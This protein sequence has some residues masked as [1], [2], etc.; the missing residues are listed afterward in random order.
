ME[1]TVRTYVQALSGAATRLTWGCALISVL[2]ASITASA[3]EADLQHG[4][5][6]FKRYCAGCHGPDGRGGAQTFMPHIDT[7]TKAGYIDLLPDEHLIGII[8]EGGPSVG[9]SSY[10]PAWGG[11]L[12]DKDINDIV[13]HIRTLPNY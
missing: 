6:L 4:E 2:F 8:K 10:M 12:S 11:T 1:G 13:A 5:R 9:K 7:L 3:Q